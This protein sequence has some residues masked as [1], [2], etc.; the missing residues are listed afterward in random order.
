MGSHAEQAVGHYLSAP[1]L[2][3]LLQN[4]ISGKKLNNV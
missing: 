3:E 4:D 1:F 2:V